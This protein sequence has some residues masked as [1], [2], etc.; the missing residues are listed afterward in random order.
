MNGAAVEL[1]PLSATV[2]ASADAAWIRSRRIALREFGP[3]DHEALLRMHRDP[4]MRAHLVDDYPLHV[5]AVVTMFLERIAPFYRR[6]EG[7]GI[8]H[9]SLLGPQP[10]FA[11]W[12]N[13]VPSAEHPGEVEIG[14]RL[15]PQVWGRGL[16]ME[17][18]ELLLGH[19]FEGLGLAQVLGICHPANRSAQ[20]VLAALGF[21]ALGEMPYEGCSATHYRIGLNAWQTSRNTSRGTRL[22]RA[23]RSQRS[24]AGSAIDRIEEEQT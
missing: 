3:H 19:A 8:W 15:L 24:N 21:E 13:L 14:S 22:R 5:S 1:D 11:G 2:P 4:R 20:A 23:L 12:F 16:A 10:A 6:Y 18:A 7:L 17:G 9:A